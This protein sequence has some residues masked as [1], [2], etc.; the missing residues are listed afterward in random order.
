[1]TFLSRRL[2]A[3]FAAQFGTK[4]HRDVNRHDTVY[5]N[6]IL[7][8]IPGILWSLPLRQHLAAFSGRILYL[9][10]A[11]DPARKTKTETSSPSV[12]QKY[13]DPR[14]RV[15]K[16]VSAI[17]KTH[18]LFDVDIAYIYLIYLSFLR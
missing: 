3:D 16:I 4:F 12:G 8:F 17:E 13:W 15:G 2:D 14:A 6:D 11:R 1:M 7:P 10:Q 18:N 9:F 5:A